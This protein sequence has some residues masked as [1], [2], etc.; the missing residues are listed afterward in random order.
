MPLWWSEFLQAK[1]ASKESVKMIA[2]LEK[3]EQ[4]GELSRTSYLADR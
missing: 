4:H 1:A 3:L 2:E